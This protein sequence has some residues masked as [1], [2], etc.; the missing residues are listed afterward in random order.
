MKSCDTSNLCQH[1]RQLY[2]T[3]NLNSRA[4][5]NSLSINTLVATAGCLLTIQNMHIGSTELC[6]KATSHVGNIAVVF[7]FVFYL[8]LTLR[9]VYVLHNCA[10]FL[11]YH[12]ACFC[13]QQTGFS[14]SHQISR[15]LTS[16]LTF[17]LT[18][19]PI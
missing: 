7:L 18:A 3:S 6:D 9:V 16:L 10:V 15:D 11:L 8:C 5:L 12:C 13:F 4:P 14:K 17:L 2:C 19:I 1:F